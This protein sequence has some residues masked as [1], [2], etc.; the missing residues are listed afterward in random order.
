MEKRRI[1]CRASF[2]SNCEQYASTAY[3]R[4]G[5]PCWHKLNRLQIP[6]EACFLIHREKKKTFI[7]RSEKNRLCYETKD[8][9]KLEYRKYPLHVPAEC[10]YDALIVFQPESIPFL[11]IEDESVLPVSSAHVNGKMDIKF[12]WCSTHHDLVPINLSISTKSICAKCETQKHQRKKR[13]FRT[14]VLIPI[15]RYPFYNQSLGWA[16]FS[17]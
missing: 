16:Y 13:K 6:I 17:K 11:H 9:K 7:Q 5:T 10:M 8:G 15:P 2:F 14:K 3:C 1:L 4:K 12:R